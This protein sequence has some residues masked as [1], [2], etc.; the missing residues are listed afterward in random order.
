MAARGKGGRND[1]LPHTS[2]PVPLAVC[3]IIV[4]V[5][6]IPPPPHPAGKVAMALVEA[7]VYHKNL[8]SLAPDVVE[9]STVQRQVRLVEPVKPPRRWSVAGGTHVQPALVH[10][11]RREAH[12]HVWLHRCPQ[13]S[14]SLDRCVIQFCREAPNERQ[15]PHTARGHS[16]LLQCAAAGLRTVHPLICRKA[17]DVHGGGGGFSREE[18]EEERKQTRIARHYR[19][20]GITSPPTCRMCLSSKWCGAHARF[21]FISLQ[22]FCRLWVHSLD[23]IDSR[24]LGAS[25]AVDPFDV[26]RTRLYEG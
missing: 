25:A 15:I 20:V 10:L 21:V 19:S 18:E 5:H 6:L 9:R 4:I 22:K 17:H 3:R 14:E 8:N 12:H 2:V 26:V 11:E 24:G 23:F 1:R 16:P 7:G 13:L